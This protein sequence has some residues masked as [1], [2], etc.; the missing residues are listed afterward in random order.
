MLLTSAVVKCSPQRHVKSQN[1]RKA[2][3]PS[4]SVT[5][6]PFRCL[7]CSNLLTPFTLPRWLL[8]LTSSRDHRGENRRAVPP[9][10]GR[11]GLVPPSSPLKRR[12]SKMDETPQCKFN[13]AFVESETTQPAR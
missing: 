6:R 4:P 8:T 5:V 7:G 11:R 3:M 13:G 9:V 2:K 10:T 12:S 1:I